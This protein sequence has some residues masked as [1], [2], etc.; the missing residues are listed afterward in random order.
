MLWNKNETF[1][2]QYLFAFETTLV[3]FVWYPSFDVFTQSVLVVS[4]HLTA[5][6]HYTKN[7]LPM[8]IQ[9]TDALAGCYKFLRNSA[10]QSVFVEA[11]RG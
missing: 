7:E 3:D 4:G 2:K 8:R 5:V 11:A 9:C 1:R 10:D 6:F